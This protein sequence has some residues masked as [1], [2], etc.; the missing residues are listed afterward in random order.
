[1]S[2][3]CT[4]GGQI[5]WEDAQYSAPGI[6]TRLAGYSCEVCGEE[7]CSRCGRQDIDAPNRMCFRCYEKVEM[8]LFCLN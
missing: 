1:M 7:Y 4:C 8:E 2:D 5:V 3:T 6:K